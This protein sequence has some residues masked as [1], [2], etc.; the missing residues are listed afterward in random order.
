MIIIKYKKIKNILNK[1]FNWKLY[2][3]LGF[4]EK[5]NFF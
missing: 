2:K 5:Y 3:K 4:F 1:Y